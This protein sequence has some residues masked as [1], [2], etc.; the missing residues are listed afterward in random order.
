VRALA[1]AIL[2]GSKMRL[3]T[4]TSLALAA[5]LICI[6]AVPA[7]KADPITVSSGG[8]SLTN[9]GNDGTGV[10]GMDSLVG[11]ALTST[12]NLN[13]GSSFIAILNPLTFTTGF[14]GLHSGGAHPFTFTQEVAINGQTQVV[15]LVGS[16][17]IGHLVDTVHILASAPI[18]FAFNTFSV[19]LTVLPAD[20]DGWGEG[21]FCG[22]LKARVEVTNNCT[23]NPVPE[24]ATLTLLGIGLVG[25]AARLRQRRR[26]KSAE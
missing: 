2:G 24:P 23:P 10:R 1:P 4:K 19:S 18:T 17:D 6:G 20:I 22:N 11:V 9:L 3:F 21:A 14:T 5:L 25:A 26:A 15:N 7:V 12:R 16:I 13:P 8:F